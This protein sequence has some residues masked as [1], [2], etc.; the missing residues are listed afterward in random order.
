MIVLFVGLICLTLFVACLLLWIGL[1]DY[2]SH[3]VIVFVAKFL[4]L[5]GLSLEGIVLLLMLN[6]FVVFCLGLCFAFL[7]W[8][9]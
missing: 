9:L 4:L 6:C 5:F 3:C 2:V 8:L 7:D 1:F